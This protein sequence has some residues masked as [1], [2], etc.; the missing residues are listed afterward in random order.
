MFPNIAET[1]YR[2]ASTIILIMG[3]KGVPHNFLETSTP[4]L[5]TEGLATQEHR[6]KR[7]EA[8]WLLIKRQCLKKE[9]TLNPLTLRALGIHGHA[10]KGFPLQFQ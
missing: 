3:P 5:L 9:G 1:Q 8:A 4:S 10:S 6:N 7:Y 2:T